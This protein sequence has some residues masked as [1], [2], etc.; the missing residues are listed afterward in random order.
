M[1]NK[2]NFKKIGIMKKKAIIN[3]I[4]VYIFT[5][6]ILIPYIFLIFSSFRRVQDI[7]AYPP[8]FFNPLTLVNY[9]RIFKDI[10]IFFFIRNSAIVAS[11]NAI[12][13][14]LFALPAAYAVARFNFKWKRSVLLVYLL[15][16]M[17]PLIAIVYPIAQLVQNI[18]IFDNLIALILFYLP[19][20]IPFAIWM[21]KPFIESIPKVLEEAAFVD[22]C[23]RFY[24]F[25]RIVIPLLLP[26]L[27]VAAI[28][29]FMGA[30]NEFVIAIF[31]T[32]DAAKTFPTTVDF[33]MTYG[34]FQWGALF[35]AA[36]LGTIPI[37]IFGL[38]LRK[39]V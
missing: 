16:Q 29:I 13:S 20:N 39:S 14:I 30:W 4:V 10:N 2:N 3:S 27:F 32:S 35:A 31:I 36:V 24:S 11:C 8:K 7:Q 17:A 1:T 12:L 19:W 25:I 22:G 18:G 33:F 9:I 37:V 23:S 26:G 28:F 15:I 34:A 5:F 38:F 6:L 21:L